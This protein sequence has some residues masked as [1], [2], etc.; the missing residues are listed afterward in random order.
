MEVEI[1]KITFEKSEAQK[2]EVYV[3]SGSFVLFFGL[4]MLISVEKFKNFIFCVINPWNSKTFYT[5][6]IHLD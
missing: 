6:N 2:S 4:P 1:R 3:N 5:T